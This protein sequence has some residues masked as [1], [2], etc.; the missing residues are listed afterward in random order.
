MIVL[1][2]SITINMITNEY[3]AKIRSLFKAGLNAYKVQL[4]SIVSLIMIYITS[5]KLG[6]K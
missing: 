2:H 5:T 3:N 6:F 1:K 4:L